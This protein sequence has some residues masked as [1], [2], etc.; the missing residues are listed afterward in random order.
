[1]S[2][3]F[4]N[5]SKFTKTVICGDNAL[6]RIQKHIA[7]KS[8]QAIGENL[9]EVNMH[10]MSI[11]ERYPLQCG[12]CVLHLSKLIMLK[13]ILFLYENLKNDSF[14]IVYTDTDSLALC[15]IDEMENLVKKERRQDWEA[16]K[17]K[18]FVVDETDPWDVRYPGK[19]KCEW[20]SSTG[21]IICLAPKTYMAKDEETKEFK[22][23]AKGIQHSVILKYEDFYNALYNDEEKFVEN[24]LIKL[25]NGKMSTFVG[26]KRGI[27][28]QFIKAYVNPDKVTVTPF[29]QNL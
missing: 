27:S 19:M 15:F 26:R 28:G 6:S 11:K 16:G 23:S 9:N 12:L 18:W 20:T 4:Q 10:T 14:S 13:F 24:N 22:K 29:A 2:T 5:P 7:F 1:L 17:Q 21:A 3:I 8:K 25:H